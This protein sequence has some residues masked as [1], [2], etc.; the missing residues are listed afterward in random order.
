MKNDI[1]RKTALYITQVIFAVLGVIFLILSFGE[2][3]PKVYTTLMLAFTDI[4][5]ILSLFVRK[6]RNNSHKGE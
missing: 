5:L 6:I 1:N 4:S 3:A 2:G